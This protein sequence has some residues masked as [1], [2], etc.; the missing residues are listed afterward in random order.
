[1]T[2]LFHLWWRGRSRRRAETRLGAWLALGVAGQVV[3]P[4]SGLQAAFGGLAGETACPTTNTNHGGRGTAAIL[5]P[6]SALHYT[7]CLRGRASVGT[8]GEHGF[9]LTDDGS[10]G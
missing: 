2:D 8:R 1:M 4:A 7:S 10:Q 9:L 5:L 3:S 6:E